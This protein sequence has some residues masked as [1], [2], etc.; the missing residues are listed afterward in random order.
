MTRAVLVS[1][2]GLVVKGEH[3]DETFMRSL[4]TPEMV[5]AV[6]DAGNV[7]AGDARTVLEPLPYQD[8]YAV[9]EI[10]DIVAA[11][12]PVGSDARQQFFAVKR[13]LVQAYQNEILM[14]YV[15]SLRKKYTVHIDAD[16]L[17]RVVA[18]MKGAQP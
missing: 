9:P 18:R 12:Q 15:A 7:Q 13:S 17:T 1:R 6:F 8:G 2:S 5:A 16:A 11:Q 4:L 3:E 14:Q 10:V